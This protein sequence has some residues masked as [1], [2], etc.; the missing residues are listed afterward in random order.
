M[1]TEYNLQATP[2]QA[3]KANTQLE[4]I[5]TEYT[6]KYNKN[7]LFDFSI[8]EGHGLS[9]GKIQEIKNQCMKYCGITSKECFVF[10]PRG[11]YGTF[12]YYSGDI[13]FK[14]YT[15]YSDSKNKR[16][17]VIMEAVKADIVFCERKSIYDEFVNT[18]EIHEHRGNNNA[19]EDIEIA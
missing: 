3:L 17:Y 4:K 15:V 5:S 14:P 13:L 16:I 2:A 1:R 10:D 18:L 6:N 12:E 19:L 9:A 8:L 7:L 11:V